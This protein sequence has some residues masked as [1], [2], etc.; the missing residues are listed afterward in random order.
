MRLS[1]PLLLLAI[2]LQKPVTIATDVNIKA[3]YCIFIVVIIIPNYFISHCFLPLRYAFCHWVSFTQTLNR[4][5]ISLFNCTVP[6]FSGL[7]FI[8]WVR[9]TALTLTTD[10]KTRTPHAMCMSKTQTDS[11]RLVPYE[12]H[13]S[14]QLILKRGSLGL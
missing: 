7:L 3:L 2:T 8:T 1:N 12:H 6:L 9:L 14:T 11:Y 10:C 13:T 4:S 5:Y